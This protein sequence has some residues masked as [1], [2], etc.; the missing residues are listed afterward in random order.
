MR[1]ILIL[2]LLLPLS[3]FAAEIVAQPEKANE[4][5][6]LDP[7]SADL[8]GKLTGF[9]HTFEFE[10]GETLPLN[11]HIFA[12][13]AEGQ[14]NDV[15]VLV[16]K[17]ERRG[18]TEIG[19]TKVNDASWNR[20]KDAVLVESF[21]EGGSLQSNLEPGSYILEVSAPN[22]D[23]RYRLTVGD[24]GRGYFEGVQALFKVKALFGSPWWTVLG[25]P[26]IY[27]PLLAA[28]LSAAAFFFYK[29]RRINHG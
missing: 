19:R 7:A 20:V 25:S 1:A 29:R 17:K 8:F 28:M 6:A 5:L 21:K 23:A 11:V 10:V 16:V 4:I 12:H 26:L 15:S 24:H 14:K 2:F 9:P 13:D 3:V 22:N 18:V 27:V